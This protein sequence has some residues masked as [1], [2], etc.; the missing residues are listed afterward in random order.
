M[1]N[2]GVVLGCGAA[3]ALLGAVLAFALANPRIVVIGLKVKALGIIALV[4]GLALLA[5][6]RVWRSDTQAGGA[7]GTR[8]PLPGSETMRTGGLV[9]AVVGVLAV[10]AIGVF[11]LVRIGSEDT[12]A[13]AIVTAAFGV[14]S[15]VVGAYLGIKIGSQA[16]AESSDDLKAAHAQVGALQALAPNQDEALAKANNAA[17]VAVRPS[18]LRPGA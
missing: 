12:S 3:L 16:A 11:A 8:A 17:E 1:R 10:V 6:A 4:F 5:L 2:R 14:I 18:R 9:V 7:G 13:V 15:A